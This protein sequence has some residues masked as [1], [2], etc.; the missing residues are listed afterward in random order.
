MTVYGLCV[1]FHRSPLLHFIVSVQNGAI[2]QQNS[3]RSRPTQPTC[4][5]STPTSFAGNDEGY[6]DGAS[7]DDGMGGVNLTHFPPTNIPQP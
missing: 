7:E 5:A 4:W 1:P 6:E 3:R 2:G